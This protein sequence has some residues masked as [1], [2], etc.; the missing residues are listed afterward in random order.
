[1]HDLGQRVGV[2]LDDVVQETNGG[3]DGLLHVVPVDALIRLHERRDVERAEVAG[4]VRQQGLL[5]A[6]IGGLNGANLRRGI[7]RAGVDAIEEHH[8]RVAR[9]PGSVDDAVEHHAGADALDNAA[10]ARIDQVIVLTGCQGLHERVRGADRDVEVGDGAVA[11]AVDEPE[12]VG[13]IDLQDAHV[14]AA[15]SAALLDLLGRFVEDTHE[16]DGSAGHAMSG[17]DHGALGRSREKAKPVPPPLLWIM[18]ACFTES[19]MPSMLSGTGSTKHADSC[20]PLFLPA[21]ISV[22]ELGMNL[23]SIMISKK[24]SSTS[25]CFL[26]LL[27]FFSASATARATRRHMPSSSSISRPS[28]FHR[29]RSART[30]LAGSDHTPALT[31]ELTAISNSLKTKPPTK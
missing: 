30:F 22:G 28:F 29:Y 16:A 27:Y 26:A 9:S 10:V 14:G 17:R 20:W 1:L 25:A 4:L 21:F 19:K 12:D 11:L 23:R 3:A 31:E 5:S 13:M 7:S 6:G 24:R 2:D 8:A 18:A 15:T